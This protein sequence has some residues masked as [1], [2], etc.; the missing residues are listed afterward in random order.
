M[1]FSNRAA[2][3]DTDHAGKPQPKGASVHLSITTPI[4]ADGLGQTIWVDLG[5]VEP[6]ANP[7]AAVRLEYASAP[8]PA[9]PRDALRM[10]AEGTVMLQVL[11]DRD[12]R[13]LDVQVQSSSGNR[14]LDEA[15]RK[16][17]LKRWTFRPAMRDG[18]AVQAI[19]I[20]PIDF[21]LAR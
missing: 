7:I 12:G 21:T 19:G 14:A 2:L 13:P 4:E 6:P 10:R 18:V 5:L 20:V 15:A 3:Q 11:V 16:H 8:P 1:S 17:V 9:Y